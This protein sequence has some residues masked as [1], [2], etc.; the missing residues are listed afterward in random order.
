LRIFGSLTA[1]SV[2][3]LLASAS[4]P[5][6]S[7]GGRPETLPG[8]DERVE[9]QTDSADRDSIREEPEEA[10]EGLLEVRR[11]AHAS[12]AILSLRG[13]G[14]ARLWQVGP[15]RSVQVNVDGSGN[16]ILGDAANEPSLAISPIDPNRIVVG[17]R[18]FD[19]VFSDFR[20]AGVAHSVDGGR[21]WSSEEVIQDGVF[22]SDPVLQS[23]A[24]GS[25][26]Y[27]SLGLPPPSAPRQYHVSLFKSVDGGV[28]WRSAV[29]ARGGDKEW[30]AIDRTTGVGR[31]NVYGSWDRVFSCCSM[32]DFVR[33]IDGG[34]SFENPLQLPPPALRWG[35]LDVGP[36]GTLYV[37]GALN[38]NSPNPPT[39]HVVSR[40]SNAQL[41][42]TAPVFEQTLHVDLGGRTATRSINNI[43]LLG[44]VWIATDHSTGPARG[45][46]YLLGSVERPGLDP[47]DVM[48]I[49]STDRGE[50]WSAPIRVNDDTSGSGAFQWF[51]S[52]AV[53]PSGRIDVIWNDTRH[54][55][56][57][58]ASEVMYSY[59]LDGG[60][61]WSKNVPVT[62]EF[63]PG[64]GYP[65]NFKLG[66]YYHL[67]SDDGGGSLAYAATFN[68]EQDV[69][70]LRIPF[71]CDG[72]GVEDDCD[73][74]CGAAGSR[75][76]VP[77]CGNGRDADGNGVLDIC[78][79][80]PPHAHAGPDQVVECSSFAGTL[81]RLD[82]SGSSDPEGGA[83]SYRWSDEFGEI[84]E[85][86]P[87]VTLSLGIHRITLQVTD[88]AG[89]ADSDEVVVT[90]RD[91][92]AP[93]VRCE[94]GTNPPGG[95][96]PSRPT[97]GALPTESGFYRLVAVDACTLESLIVV[98][99]T[100][101]SGPFGPFSSGT[102]VKMTQAP[103]GEARVA[104]IG[105]PRGESGAI[106]MHLLLPGE[107][108]IG[109]R[110]GSG[111][112]AA[113]ACPLPPRRK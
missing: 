53:A 50:T 55:P 103:G 85:A 21:S 33:S 66:D 3:A 24:A 59:S 22:H 113:A 74:A 108:I 64:I 34:A 88:A 5:A 15:Y 58:R 86:S 46:V 30:F 105:S 72:N 61:T 102:A 75:C 94:V 65:Q 77:G 81:V 96:T 16:N 95:G 80:A 78:G 99:D 36:D 63:D 23:D 44:Q 110:D 91:T 14:P 7:A 67:L 92:T 106:S 40:S 32:T 109:S 10:L 70:F 20:E 38:L 31:G 68:G 17:W 39:G 71:D 26:Y 37:A 49:R 84:E 11:D 54:D 48:F 69:Y 56:A 111:N 28:S 4:L 83:L 76:G 51:G 12:Q 89:A 25:F 13:V 97:Q 27:F 1:A 43:G 82:G 52:L 41:R 6:R 9:F 73:I 35:A 112:T 60:V 18:Q 45:N 98:S 8:D 79:N 62:P 47:A 19:S 29:D 104:S 2:L 100:A 42:S 101:G 93:V 107:P 90:I 57:K 87:T